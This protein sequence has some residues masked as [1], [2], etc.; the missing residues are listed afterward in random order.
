VDPGDFLSVRG[1]PEEDITGLSALGG[2]LYIG[3]RKAIWS[4]SGTI[5]TATNDTNATG[6][7]PPR[8]EHRLLRTRAKSGPGDVY[9]AGLY[10]AGSP[11]RLFFVNDAGVFQFDGIEEQMVSVGIEPTWDEFY[12]FPV[13]MGGTM[14]RAISFGYDR[15]YDTLYIATN[16][17]RTDG[18][19]VFLSLD[20]ANGGWATH[21]VAEESKPY[22]SPIVSCVA[23]S[24]SGID[25]RNHLGSGDYLALVAGYPKGVLVSDVTGL[26]TSRIPDFR[27]TSGEIR[28]I[29]GMDVHVYLVKWMLGNGYGQQT[30]P[31]AL[32]KLGVSVKNRESTLDVDVSQREVIRQSVRAEGPSLVLSIRRNENWTGPWSDSG[33]IGWELDAQAAGQK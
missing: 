14:E 19:N 22:S 15:R 7:V 2:Q 29:P 16:R 12:G 21:D 20:L 32:F 28:P 27:W 26:T 6:A 13:R 9:G 24:S 33:I 25:L 11:L 4:L 1:D 5:I 8:S 30:P 17:K 3:K 18:T 31:A 10:P 23:S